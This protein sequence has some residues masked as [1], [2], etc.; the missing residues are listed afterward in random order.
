MSIVEALPSPLG[1][2]RPYIRS[3]NRYD[4]KRI[5]KF[6]ADIRSPI[7]ALRMISKAEIIPAEVRALIEGSILRISEIAR[8][9]FEDCSPL[10]QS[11]DGPLSSEEFLK[12]LEQLV[13]EKRTLFEGKYSE[14][15]WVNNLTESVKV[16]RFNDKRVLSHLLDNALE[17][18]ASTH[19]KVSLEV[20]QEDSNFTLIIRDNGQGV[21]A[22]FVERVGR[23]GFSYGKRKAFGLGAFFARKEVESVG[24][25]FIFESTL[26]FGSKTTVKIPSCY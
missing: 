22:H 14:F 24:G 26:G 20:M 7:S 8:E 5:E 10:T 12:N 15:K 6:L 11:L 4:S 19:G 2:H 21:P 23:R 16:R 9:L 13:E 25:Q 18:V 3:A 1:L 17:A